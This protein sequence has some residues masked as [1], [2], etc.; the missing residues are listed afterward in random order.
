[1]I[2]TIAEDATDH[3]YYI[4][5][6]TDF[7]VTSG[8]VTVNAE[9]FRISERCSQETETLINYNYQDDDGTIDLV[10]D[11]DLD[12]YDNSTSGFINANGLDNSQTRHLTPMVLVTHCLRRVT[13]TS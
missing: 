10:V 2:H 6:G 5:D 8:D 13:L 11:N 1:M 3:G 12:N 9:R 7:T 4:F